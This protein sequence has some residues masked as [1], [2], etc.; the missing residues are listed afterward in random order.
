MMLESSPHP[1][2]T[3]QRHLANQRRV[4]GADC[5]LALLGLY[6]LSDRFRRNVSGSTNVVG[7]CPQGRESAP[8]K[9]ELVTQRM[10][11]VSLQPMHDLVWRDCRRERNK[12]VD[13]IGPHHQFKNVAL[14]LCHQLMQHDNQPIAHRA[15]QDGTPILRA[16]HKVI[17]DLVR[18]VSCLLYRHTTYYTLDR[19]DLSNESDS[20]ALPHPF[21]NRVSPRRGRVVSIRKGFPLWVWP[22]LVNLL[23]GWGVGRV[24][25]AGART[26]SHRMTYLRNPGGGATFAV[27][28][29]FSCVCPSP[30][31]RA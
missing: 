17:V 7:A 29:R 22:C 9:R 14:H 18:R 11:R 24:R 5:S 31:I 4:E 19:A 27:G 25:A 26:H 1:S 8:E 16:P 15:S 3:V 21:K 23:H 12:Q 13:M 10:T 28:D 6:I 20:T 2:E 30:L